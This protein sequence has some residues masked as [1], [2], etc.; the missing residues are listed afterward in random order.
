MHRYKLELISVSGAMDD[1]KKAY[2]QTV[3][4]IGDSLRATDIEKLDYFYK[5]ELQ[6]RRSYAHADKSWKTGLALLRGLEE[7]GVFSHSNPAGLASA[8]GEV[9]REDLKKMVEEFVG[10]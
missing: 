3:A 4:D 5:K 8:M 7:G 1:Y 10:E 2:Q 9:K 6:S